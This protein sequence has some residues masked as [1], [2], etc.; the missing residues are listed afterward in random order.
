VRRAGY[1]CEVC[2]LDIDKCGYLCNNILEKGTVLDRKSRSFQMSHY[3]NGRA[4]YS[5]DIHA[6]DMQN[7]IKYNVH[8]VAE[9][10]DKIVIEE[11]KDGKTVHV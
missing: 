4:V 3:T 11:H 9:D 10:I 6:K 8:D 5:I 2:D 1:D 7:A